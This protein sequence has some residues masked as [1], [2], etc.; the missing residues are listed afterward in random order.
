[1]YAW[2]HEP[3]AS[4]PRY[5]RTSVVVNYILGFSFGNCAEISTHI[6]KIGHPVFPHQSLMTNGPHQWASRGRHVQWPRETAFSILVPLL[7]HSPEHAGPTLCSSTPRFAAFFTTSLIHASWFF[8]KLVHLPFWASNQCQ[9][10]FGCWRPETFGHDD[11][12]QEVFA[13]PN[14]RRF[15]HETWAWANATSSA[16][17]RLCLGLLSAE[18]SMYAGSRRLMVPF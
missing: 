16:R 7:S 3:R 15:C 9:V 10:H 1:M 13:M 2:E 17:H 5:A 11:R 18:C 8:F 12:I 6:G 4:V 14:R